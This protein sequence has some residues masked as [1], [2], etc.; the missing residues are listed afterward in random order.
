MSKYNINDVEMWAEYYNS[1]YSLSKVSEKFNVPTSTVSYYLNKFSEKVDY[2]SINAIQNTLLKSEK[3]K[4]L[5][6]LNELP[7]DRFDKTKNNN[8]SSICIKCTKKKYKK[9]YIEN[10]DKITKRVSKWREDNYKR[11]RENNNKSTRKWRK[12]NPEKYVLSSHES[13]KKMRD[14]YY[15]TNIDKNIREK[16]DKKFCTKCKTY[17]KS[18][19]FAIKRSNKCGLATMCKYCY[20]VYYSNYSKGMQRK[21]GV[22]LRSRLSRLVK[23]K[24]SHTFE[25]LGCSVY[26]L[27]EY[28]EKKFYIRHDGEKMSWKNYGRH[29]WHI[30]HIQPLSMFDLQ[31][32][33]Q[34]KIACHYTNLQP[35]W[36]EDN[37][38]KSNKIKRRVKNE[39]SG[40]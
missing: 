18:S 40:L 36:A 12:E 23:N 29:G 17:R 10:V 33:S 7:I 4:C 24:K 20:K 31:D 13:N 8:L 25:Y 5:C 15:K 35:L 27:L 21:I 19:E 38:R 28:L 1:V 22:T 9:W 11:F 26:E 2:K 3:R 30:D 37:L 16:V 39:F 14:K 6:C 32:E 34:L